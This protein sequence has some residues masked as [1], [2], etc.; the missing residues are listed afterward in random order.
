MGSVVFLDAIDEGHN[1][2]FAERGEEVV[3][4]S[5]QGL[6]FDISIQQVFHSRH[7][8]VVG[9]VSVVGVA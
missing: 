7:V 3:A 2:P 5:L 9:V 1:L 6:L 8:V 4:E